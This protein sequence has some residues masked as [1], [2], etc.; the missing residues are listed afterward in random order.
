MQNE[1]QG[2]TQTPSKHEIVHFLNLDRYLN[3]NVCVCVCVMQF[4]LSSVLLMFLRC[5]FLDFEVFSYYFPNGLCPL[6]LQLL[7]A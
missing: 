4:F 3:V 2:P 6:S 1:V 7:E 5:C